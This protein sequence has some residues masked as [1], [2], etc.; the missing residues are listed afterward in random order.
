MAAQQKR[1][2]KNMWAEIPSVMPLDPFAA[3][4]LR[5]ADPL[6]AAAV[7]ITKASTAMSGLRFCIVEGA[8]HDD[9]GLGADKQ[10]TPDGFSQKS[11]LNVD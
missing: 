8:A 9:R 10:D 6:R 5:L 11:N 2:L 1:P 7:A 4:T 3:A